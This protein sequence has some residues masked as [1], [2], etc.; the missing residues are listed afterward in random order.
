MN[1][2]L[3]NLTEYLKKGGGIHIKEKNKG[4]F[5]KYC[6]GKVTQAC[7]DKAKKSG[8][9]KL[10]KKAVFAENARKWKKYS[11][12]GSMLDQYTQYLLNQQNQLNK[13]NENEQL[14]KDRQ[15][16]LL[17]K[18]VLEAKQLGSSLGKVVGEAIGNT[19]NQIHQKNELNKQIDVMQE[20][21]RNNVKKQFNESLAKKENELNQRDKKFKAQFE[22]DM[23][24]LG[25]KMLADFKPLEFTPTPILTNSTEK[26]ENPSISTMTDPKTGTGGST[27]N[28]EDRVITNLL[29][30][31]P[32]ESTNVMTDP[33]TVDLTEEAVQGSQTYDDLILQSELRSQARR[34]AAKANINQNTE[35]SLHGDDEENDE[36][37]DP[38]S[39]QLLD[40]TD[41]IFANDTYTNST[42]IKYADVKYGRGNYKLMYFGPDQSVGVKPI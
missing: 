15:Q 4:S 9:K 33:T 8:N 37:I 22:L 30:S 18:R 25:D 32:T 40:P 31:S 3:R 29:A 36:E 12:G 21:A 2:N 24:G 27:E 20:K 34:N 26:V 7:I 17:E 35:T 13:Y 14:K 11:T 42:A 5:T 6:N 23:K 16:Q 38:N 10:I 19:T 28:V 41:P 39:Y 1:I